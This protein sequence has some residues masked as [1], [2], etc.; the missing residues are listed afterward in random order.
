MKL[1]TCLQQ[2]FSNYLPHI[3]GVS[4]HTINAYRDAF[5][6]FIPFAANHLKIKTGSL[7]LE[8]LTADMVLAFL[9]DLE[10]K[11]HQGK[12]R[13]KLTLHKRCVLV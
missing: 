11:R 4:P 9:A 7:L 1:T 5:T 10:H 13:N 6:L 12:S 2:F 3:K 8:H